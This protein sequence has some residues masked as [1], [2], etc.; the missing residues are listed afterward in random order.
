MDKVNELLINNMYENYLLIYPKN[1]MKN[2]DIINKKISTNNSITG[3]LT[4]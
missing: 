2:I 3:K 4:Q 1:L